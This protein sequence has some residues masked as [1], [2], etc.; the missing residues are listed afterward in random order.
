MNIVIFSGGTGSIALQTGLKNLIPDCT[1]TNIINAFDDGKST[2][3]CRQIMD[4]PGPSDI[5][6]NHETQYKNKYDKHS[7]N[8]NIIEFLSNRYDLP[9]GQELEFCL[10]KLDNWN[11]LSQFGEAIQVFFDTYNKSIHYQNFDFTDFNI[12]NIVYS[13]MFAMYGVEYTI[14]KMKDFFNL[15]DEILVITDKNYILNAKTKNGM[16]LN[17]E[18]EIVNFGLNKS[19]DKITELMVY[20]NSK[21]YNIHKFQPKLM[22]LN[23]I[24]VNPKVL[25]TIITADVII[26]SAGTQFASLISTYLSG[27]IIEYL[28]NTNCKKIFIMNMVEDLD[29]IGWDSNDI[30]DYMQKINLPITSV[31]ISNDAAKGLNDCNPINNVKKIKSNLRFNINSHTHD[32]IKLAKVCVDTIY[33]LNNIRIENKNLHSQRILIDFDDT[34]WSRDTELEVTSRENLDLVNTLSKYIDISIVSGNSYKSLQNKMSSI[35]GGNMNVDFDIWADGGLVKY[36]NNKIEYFDS[37]NTLNQDEIMKFLYSD[38]Y[39]VDYMAEYGDINFDF[40][41]PDNAPTVITLKPIE[42]EFIRNLICKCINLSYLSKE[43]IA[44][45][46]GRT[47]V[48]I[49]NNQANKTMALK[50]Y[51][52]KNNNLRVYYIGDECDYGNDVE[53]A[54][55]SNEYYQVRTIKETNAILKI[56]LEKFEDYYSRNKIRG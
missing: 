11:L 40:R 42:S 46:S 53:I 51:T 17:S 6:K 34:I 30:L 4:V 27:K 18:S 24:E 3:I 10:N 13:S 26:Y 20:L 45:K 52:N 7:R 14:L 55:I 36:K 19:I 22:P 43:I 23:E 1:I 56:L 5:R 12:A 49:I 8:Q 41:G 25:E 15:D 38:L 28:N 48:D 31:I 21:K 2:G 29:M 39:I 44:K 32:P 50:Y 35:F 33:N 37:N 54:E 16:Y 47:S 9:K